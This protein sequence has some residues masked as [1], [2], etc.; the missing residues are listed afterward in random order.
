M[1]PETVTVQVR[2]FA[3]LRDRLG[4]ASLALQVPAPAN[5]AALTEALLAEF[6]PNV[7]TELARSLLTASNVRI[8][9]N[10]A[11]IETDC[12]LRAG[13]E[14]AFLPPVTGG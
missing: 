12:V 6:A 4:R 3:E 11:L 7:E 10:Q 1:K 8:A 14:V 13:D 5:L 9:V 2:L